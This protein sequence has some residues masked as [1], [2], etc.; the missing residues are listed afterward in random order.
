MMRT[1][2]ASLVLLAGCLN[3]D[4]ILG[5]DDEPTNPTNPNPPSPQPVASGTYDVRSSIDITV[6]AILPETA[7]EAVVTLRDFST[8]PAHTLLDLAEQAG[9]PAVGTIRAALPDVVESKLEGWIDA[10]IAKVTIDGVPVTQY[11]GEIAALA[12][13]ALTTFALDSEL[14][15]TGSSATHALTAIDLT[16]AGIDARIAIGALPSDIVSATTIC[17]SKNAT[18]TLG[19]HGYALAYGQYIWNAIDAKLGGIRAKVGA[20]VNCPNIASRVAAKCV[21]SVCVGHQAE[22]TAIC[23]RGL[24]EVVARAEA[25]VAELRF[26]ALHF[27]AGRAT[28][29]DANH[30]GNVEALANGT[31]TAELN[32]G[33]GLRPVPATFTAPR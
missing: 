17:T 22:L 1:T 23:E 24:D 2:F 28:L 30:D 10:E 27:E 6:E 3:P 29:V 21:L 12:E 8:A 31:W 7:Y 5:G 33:Q 32:A 11:A 9:V 25:K 16:P 26:D 18:L 4:P 14:T 13:T 20:A 15:I 19:D